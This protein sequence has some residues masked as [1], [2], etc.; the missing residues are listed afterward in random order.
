MTKQCTA[1]ND[2]GYWWGAEVIDPSEPDFVAGKGI[3]MENPVRCQY[4]AEAN[5]LCGKHDFIQ[6]NTAVSEPES[7]EQSK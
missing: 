2:R 6:R 4:V 7:G 1:V 3:W 5:G